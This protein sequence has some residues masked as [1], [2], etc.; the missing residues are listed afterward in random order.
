MIANWKK[1][2]FGFAGQ[3][4]AEIWSSITLDT[5][6]IVSEYIQPNESQVDNG[7]IIS[8]DALWMHKH[9]RTSQYFTQIVKCDDKLCCKSPRSSYFNFFPQFFPPPIP[10]VQSEKGVF[11]S[12]D[13]SNEMDSSKFCSLFLSNGLNYDQILPDKFKHFM[14]SIPY[15]LYCP[16]IHNKLQSRICK[17]CGTYFASIVMLTAHTKA[18]HKRVM[19]PPMIRPVRVAAKRQREIMAIIAINEQGDEDCEWIDVENVDLEESALAQICKERNMLLPIVTIDEHLN[20]PWED[21]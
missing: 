10:I 18:V 12:T 16:S 5:F 1:K 14:P 21:V 3:C 20:S 8:K 15:D 17:D 6:P 9:C 11:A 4:L 19:I 13:P 7:K 2:N